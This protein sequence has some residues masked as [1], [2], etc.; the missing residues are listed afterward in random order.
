MAANMVTR[1]FSESNRRDDWDG[2]DPETSLSSIAR[3]VTVDFN[4]KSHW[5]REW[6]PRDGFR[7]LARNW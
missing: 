5:H 7:E 2:D 4:M 6:T 3:S 1:N